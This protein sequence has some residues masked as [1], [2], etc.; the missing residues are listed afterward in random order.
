[1]KWFIVSLYL[2]KEGFTV[3]IPSHMQHRLQKLSSTS[4]VNG[5]NSCFSFSR[6]ESHYIRRRELAFG[7]PPLLVDEPE[8]II[9]KRRT[10]CSK[11]LRSILSPCS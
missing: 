2:A 5:K 7:V 3:H 9:P 4:E 6:K 11:K 8:Q 1:M 10:T